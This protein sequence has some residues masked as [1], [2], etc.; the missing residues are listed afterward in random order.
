MDEKKL[1]AI[2]ENISELNYI[3]AFIGGSHATGLSN[4]LSDIDIILIVNNCENEC[5]IENI[6][7]KIIS[8]NE[9]NFLLNDTRSNNKIES[10]YEMIIADI[11]Y[12]IPICNE[13]EFNAIRQKISW[14]KVSLKM[15][16]DRMRGYC[17]F[18]LDSKKFLEVGD[19]ISSLVCMQRALE[20]LIDA[21]LFS[22]Q[23]FIVKDKWRFKALEKS[24]RYIFFESIRIIKLI[25]SEQEI[26]V[27]TK[28]YNA[29]CKKI[30]KKI[31]EMRNDYE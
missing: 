28:K 11:Y 14:E 31:T 30:L 23:E 10:R 5:A 4:N 9:L 22:K 12:G 16:D 26:K 18:N 1:N 24:H 17:Y 29:F 21:Y 25:W 7:L 20:Q 2:K 13:H 27:K 19:E 15:I 8:L 3:C 6:D